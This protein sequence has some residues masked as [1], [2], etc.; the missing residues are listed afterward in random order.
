MTVSSQVLGSLWEKILVVCPIT[1]LRVPDWTDKLTWIVTYAVNDPRWGTATPE[2]IT[3]CEALIAAY[4]PQA[5]SD[6]IDAR[7]AAIHGA[8][9]RS[10]MIQRLRTATPSQINNWVDA[11]LTNIADA[12]TIVKKI[13]IYLS[14]PSH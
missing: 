9:D 10:D 12:R 14:V 11:N 5:D 2:Q 4:D 3:A 8:F 1:N 6:A 7:D 13:L